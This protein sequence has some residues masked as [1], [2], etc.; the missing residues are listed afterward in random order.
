[1]QMGVEERQD[2][3]HPVPPSENETSHA[4]RMRGMMTSMATD[5]HLVVGGTMIC[6]G[7]IL[8]SDEP[9]PMMTCYSGMDMTQMR[10]RHCVSV[11]H[12]ETDR[13]GAWP[14][15]GNSVELP[16]QKAESLKRRKDR[17]WDRMTQVLWE[18]QA[19]ILG[20]GGSSSHCWRSKACVGRTCCSNVA[21]SS[22]SWAALNRC[23]ASC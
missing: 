8:T 4:R 16:F 14:V 6:C 22:W 20:M 15:N 3:G 18:T 2:I 13:V 7:N 17:M 21:R 11:G 5:N 12:L 19:V 10:G 1:M 23:A 9:I